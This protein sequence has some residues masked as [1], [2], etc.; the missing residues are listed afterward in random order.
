MEPLPGF[1]DG[2]ASPGTAVHSRL[3]RATARRILIAW[4]LAA[5]THCADIMS[6]VLK[7]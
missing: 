6:A 4:A 5:A 2:A 7:A 3:H 1:D